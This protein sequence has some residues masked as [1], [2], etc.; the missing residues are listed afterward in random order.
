MNNG[1]KFKY[2]GN[3]FPIYINELEQHIYKLL[4]N[5]ED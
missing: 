4:Y 1:N 3:N 5:Y 2:T